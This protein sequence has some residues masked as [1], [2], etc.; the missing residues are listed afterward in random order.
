MCRSIDL[1]HAFFSGARSRYAAWP[2]ARPLCVPLDTVVRSV[3]GLPVRAPLFPGAA[4]PL[5][6]CFGRPLVPLTRPALSVVPSR[7]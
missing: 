6:P 3:Q 7:R 5:S 4:I 2:L 1:K